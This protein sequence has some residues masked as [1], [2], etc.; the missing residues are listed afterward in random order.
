[1][2]TKAE[3]ERLRHD[4]RY[5]DKQGNALTK[6]HNWSPQDEDNLLTTIEE[7]RGHLGHTVHSNHGF[8]PDA[9][10]ACAA[11]REALE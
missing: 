2:L 5:T 8:K 10:S 6:R 7:L 3:C 1:M 9:C 4:Y 11:A